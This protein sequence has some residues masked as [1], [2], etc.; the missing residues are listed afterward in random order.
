MESLTCSSGTTKL[1]NAKELAQEIEVSETVSDTITSAQEPRPYQDSIFRRA[2]KENI[3]A[4]L[5]TGT[6]K[7]LIA[8]LLAKQFSEPLDN[9]ASSV[10]E[11]LVTQRRVGIIN[12]SNLLES[13]P[14]LNKK[15]VF[16]VP[17]T[18]LVRQQAL[19]LTRNAELV[20]KEYQGNVS[21]FQTKDIEDAALWHREW[22]QAQALV[23]TP[24]ILLNLLKVSFIKMSDISLLI[25]D[26]AHHCCGDHAYVH[27]MR[28]YYKNS[29]LDD[30]P[31]IFGMTASPLNGKSNSEI[32]VAEEI[33][34]LQNN[35]MSKIVTVD[36]KLIDGY[37]PRANTIF[38][39]YSRQHSAYSMSR[40]HFFMTNPGEIYN[41]SDPVLRHMLYHRQLLYKIN[42]RIDKN[43]RAGDVIKEELGVWL[44]GKWF[45]YCAVGKTSTA[46]P[47]NAN[48]NAFTNEYI[49]STPLA[50]VDPLIHFTN[51]LNTLVVRLNKLYQRTDVKSLIFIDRKCIV[52][53]LSAFL[54]ELSQSD[55][56]PFNCNPWYLE[57]SMGEALKSA[58]LYNFNQGIFNL[59][60]TTSVAE[61]GLDISACNV[62]FMF[63]VPKSSKSQIQTRGRARQKNSD[64]IVFVEQ[65]DDSKLKELASRTAEEFYQNGMIRKLQMVDISPQYSEY[66]SH[67]TSL[68]D[69]ESDD[70]FR[71]GNAQCNKYDAFNKLEQ[72][73]KKNG[74]Y[75]MTLIMM[76]G[77]QST[78][79][80][81]K[82]LYYRKVQAYRIR[83]KCPCN[84][85]PPIPLPPVWNCN[86][87]RDNDLDDY[88]LNDNGHPHNGNIYDP[89]PPYSPPTCSDTLICYNYAYQIQFTSSH[90]QDELI[91]G[92][93]RHL[94]KDAKQVACLIAIKR[95]ASCNGFDSNMLP[96]GDTDTGNAKLHKL[97]HSK[98]FTKYVSDPIEAVDSGIDYG[99]GKNETLM[100][101]DTL[102]E[103]VRATSSWTDRS[104]NA[105]LIANCSN[106]QVY[107]VSVSYGPEAYDYLLSSG[108][109]SWGYALLNPP[110]YKIPDCVI[111][112]NNTIPCRVEYT[113]MDPIVLSIGE[114]NN[115]LKFQSL[116]YSRTT[117]PM[118]P[119]AEKNNDDHLAATHYMN[120]VYL[121][122]LPLIDVG[123]VDSA[124]SNNTETPLFTPASFTKGHNYKIEYITHTPVKRNYKLD[125]SCIHRITS[126]FNIPMTRLAQLV[127]LHPIDELLNKSFEEIILLLKSDTKSVRSCSEYNQVSLLNSLSQRIPLSLI[128]NNRPYFIL[129]FVVLDIDDAMDAN[130]AVTYRDFYLSKYN[131]MLTSG[132]M[133]KTKNSYT[134]SNHQYPIISKK[135]N[136]NKQDIYIP[137]QACNLNTLPTACLKYNNI[138]PSVFHHLEHTLNCMDIMRE[139]EVGKNEHEQSQQ[140]SDISRICQAMTHPS[141]LY[142]H[143]YERLEFLGDAILKYAV[144][145][146]LFRLHVNWTEGQLSIQRD[147]LVRN[148]YLLTI[149]KRYKLI[150]RVYMKHY[151]PQSY[152]MH[153]MDI[154]KWSNI[155]NINKW[156]D[157]SMEQWDGKRMISNK[158]GADLVESLIGAVYC[159]FGL[160]TTLKMMLRMGL[161]SEIN[162][163]TDANCSINSGGKSI[164]ILPYTFKNE[165]VYNSCTEMHTRE[166]DR[167]EYLGDAV[168]DYCCALY[169]YANYPMYL[170]NKLT[171]FKQSIVQNKSFSRLCFK[172]RLFNYMRESTQL[173]EKLN[174]VEEWN[175]EEY[176]DTISK[177]YK[178][179]GDI[180]ESVC[181]GI[182]MDNDFDVRIMWQ[183]MGKHVCEELI[184]ESA[185]NQS[186]EQLLRE[187]L[188][189]MGITGI[190]KL[191]PVKEQGR[192][193]CTVYIDNEKRGIGCDVELRKAIIKASWQVVKIYGNLKQLYEFK[194]Q[195]SRESVMVDIFHSDTNY[196]L[197]EMP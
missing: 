170:P 20:V 77:R 88:Y 27:I 13:L 62:V 37:T 29:C 24:Q 165:N 161:L 61:E 50:E 41:V 87:N 54:I 69:V 144:G 90:V 81:Q 106:V 171:A 186:Q 119:A 196:Y 141:A 139:L 49:Q 60:A 197:R 31:R 142:I 65:G 178:I 82:Y 92:P 156:T 3:I 147:G 57:S 34:E 102:C 55:I 107:P 91:V 5:E 97:L 9:I 83:E 84:Y 117:R 194:M 95:L 22:S 138:N 177:N 12:Q 185:T 155:K 118:N 176:E 131:I 103:Y 189:K 114:Y 36:P 16:L 154:S 168:L 179:L 181:G 166:F 58:A 137:I 72:Y 126:N 28:D 75:T 152:V 153:Q 129:S 110:I 43:I 39:F 53:V 85:K 25:F 132:I 79:L 19:Q 23:M 130:S 63:D 158:N 52:Y 195:S 140:D 8:C 182:L 122:L 188:K 33:N 14:K 78:R 35:L 26:E 115:L 66:Y 51:K 64:Y 167:L 98:Q 2:L 70:P 173:F 111:W 148:S 7:T 121:V 123:V 96:V 134:L 6:G 93:P 100:N 113:L 15:V 86:L 40:I 42:D 163:S 4:F 21:H 47:L 174:K 192:Y 94:I 76:P 135:K 159:V 80:M 89:F 99:K 30:R 10:Y 193:T 157:S 143:N 172:L 149:S 59:L 73:S 68:Q 17:K 120:N 11:L 71:V 187:E 169:S 116:F 105:A 38:V 104:L 112:I 160:Q 146:N 128:C 150:N 183:V 109:Y 125:Y 74:D 136:I 108:R 151:N 101:H 18:P 127:T 162:I 191:S 45:E 175:I 145:M 32:K 46:F 48:S 184:N 67:S 56:I 133:I 124:L 180:F 1:I 44:A 190:C 164:A